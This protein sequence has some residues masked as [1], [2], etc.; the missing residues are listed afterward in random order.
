VHQVD[1]CILDEIP[2]VLLLLTLRGM[3]PLMTKVAGSIS[4]RKRD[5]DYAANAAANR[6]R[7][8]S[9]DDFPDSTPSDS[10]NRLST[11]GPKQPLPT[12]RVGWLSSLRMGLPVFGGGGSSKVS[13]P[14][15]VIAPTQSSS[16]LK[17][18]LLLPSPRMRSGKVPTQP[19]TFELLDELRDYNSD[20]EM[21]TSKALL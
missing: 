9:Q 10:E 16:R 21:P 18:G 20:P 17:A 12:P 3:V 1:R 14:S 11:E 2:C 5:R 13:I 8:F 7:F 6:G 15:P 19:P 4:E